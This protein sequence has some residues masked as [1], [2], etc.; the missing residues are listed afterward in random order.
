MEDEQAV[1]GPAIFGFFSKIPCITAN[2]EY[3]EE[4]AVDLTNEEKQLYK[5]LYQQLVNHKKVIKIVAKGSDASVNKSQTFEQAKGSLT[6]LNLGV[7][8]SLVTKFK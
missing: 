7:S 6:K 5:P 3:N 8:F 4:D 1:F 2:K